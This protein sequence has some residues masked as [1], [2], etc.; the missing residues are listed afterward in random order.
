MDADE[1]A[2]IESFEGREAYNETLMSSD[3]YLYDARSSVPMLTV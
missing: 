2:V 3:Y 1:Q